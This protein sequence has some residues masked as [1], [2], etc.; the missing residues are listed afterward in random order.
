[1]LLAYVALADG[2]G[3]ETSSVLSGGGYFHSPL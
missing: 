3:S 2:R 1:M